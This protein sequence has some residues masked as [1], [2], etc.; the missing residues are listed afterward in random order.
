MYRR[1]S[2]LAFLISVLICCKCYGQSQD[3]EFHLGAHLLTGQNILKVKRDFHDV[4]LWALGQN[5]TVY[6]VNSTTLAVDDYTTL[7]APYSN[8]QFVDIMGHSADTVFV[9]TKSTNV[10]EYAGGTFKLIGSA[11]GI[12]DTVNSIGIDLGWTLDNNQTTGKMLFATNHGIRTFDPNTQT[13][14]FLP[15]TGAYATN[16]KIAK[17]HVFESTYRTENYKDS[18]AGGPAGMPD[19][20]FSYLPIVFDTNSPQEGYDSPMVTSYIWEDNKTFGMNALTALVL[21]DDVGN[22]DDGSFATMVWGGQNGMFETI[23]T[24][25][26]DIGITGWK[27]YLNGI[28]VNKITNILGLTSFSI[29]YDMPII[30][31]NLLIGTNNGLYFSSSVY[32]YIG[33]YAPPFSLFHFADMGSTVI[34]DICVNAVPDAK[35]IC[36]NGVWLGAADGLYFIKPDYGAFFN[37]QRQKFITFQNQ[38]DTL[39]N[40]LLCSLSKATATTQS[41]YTNI[42]WYK[43]GAELPGQTQ[44]SLSINAAGD[45]NAVIY[46]PC[47]GLHLESNHL[48]VTLITN[49]VFTFNY[50][51]VIA[52]CGTKPDTLNVTYS[53]SYHY[54]WY[55]NG[56]LN[57]D[58]TSTFVATQSGQYYVVVSACSGTWVPS[59]SVQVDMITLPTPNITPGQASYCAEDT[60]TLSANVPADTSYTITWYRNDTLVVAGNGLPTL[61]TLTAG[62]YTVTVTSHLAGCTQTSAPFDLTFVPGPV[63][64]SQPPPT[65]VS[66]G[67]VSFSVQGPAGEHLRWYTNGVLNGDTTATFIAEQSGT[68]F[69]QAS[70]CPGA[71]VSSDTV[72]I[73]VINL[74]SPTVTADKTDYCAG[75]NAV[76]TE[77]VS[78]DPSYTINWYLGSTLLTANT[79]QTSITTNVS[80]S[81]SVEVVS[82]VQSSDGNNCSEKSVSQLITINPTP[83]VSINAIPENSFCDGQTVELVASFNNGS[84]LWSTG[85]TSGSIRVTQSGTYKVT[86][87]SAAGCQADTSIS[88]TFLA[89]PVFTVSDTSICEYK[90]QPVTLTAPGGFAA[91][92]WNGQSGGQTYTVTQAGPVNLTITDADGC[93]VTQQIQVADVCAAVNIPNTFTPNGDGVNDTWVVEGLDESATVKVFTRWGKQI[94]QS[95]GYP[96]PWNGEY[97]GKRLPQGVYYYVITAKNNTQKLSGWVTIIY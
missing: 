6:R 14:G 25:S 59:S 11:A 72:K 8:L 71:W 38:P 23:A 45:Y 15:D 70:T 31:Q 48:K 58:T 86:V 26:Y 68:I 66:C 97:D 64:Q 44:N 40:L 32:N 12:P 27:Q 41:A 30:K 63:F 16:S 4:Y 50:P 19:S 34:N 80:G 76:L 29:Y 18:L 96:S 62:T 60:A 52:Q 83:T 35:P 55:T 54:R 13:I 82:N 90:R 81:Y 1:I 43:D 77:N 61:K 24:Y 75:D 92:N 74:P 47:E 20:L 2:S 93:K 22:S 85:E 91:Y 49:P 84:L 69:V 73:T 79:N 65:Y 87:T 36:E 57:G 46:D 78:T 53:Q 33:V 7:F 42:Q 56:T 89:N 51:P 28:K 39:S 10:I 5:N 95:V 67:P 37:N 9:A 21:D 17:G 3:V 94:F 88:V